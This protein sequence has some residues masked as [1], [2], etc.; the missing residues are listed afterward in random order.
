MPT[1]NHNKA[2]LLDTV[3]KVLIVCG[4]LFQGVCEKHLLEDISKKWPL[5]QVPVVA[6]DASSSSVAF[7]APG[8]PDARSHRVLYVAASH[9]QLGPYRSQ[10]EIPAISSRSLKSHEIIRARRF[11]QARIKIASQFL[12]TFRI[13]YVSGKHQ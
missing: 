7:I 5:V 13:R 8:L 10:E 4:S 2:L 1:D 12:E 9:T 3:E 6:N 11:V